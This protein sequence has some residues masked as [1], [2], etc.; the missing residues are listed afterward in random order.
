MPTPSLFPVFMLA[1][2]GGGTPSGVVGGF[3]EGEV[4]PSLIA[5]IGPDPLAAEVAAIE[6]AAE[7][8]PSFTA[9]IGG[10]IVAEIGP[11][12]IEAEIE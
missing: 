4:E 6:L 3:I 5:S 9:S 1:R 8:K 2:S 12:K 11:T 10:D 7:I